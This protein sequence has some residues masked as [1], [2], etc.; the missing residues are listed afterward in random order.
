MVKSFSSA[1]GAGPGSVGMAPYCQNIKMMRA[2]IC[3]ANLREE[4]AK[5]G[6]R[7]AS[8][9]PLDPRPGW[10]DPPRIQGL[11]P[12]I[13]GAALRF[14]NIIDPIPGLYAPSSECHV[15]LGAEFSRTETCKISWWCHAVSRS[16]TSTALILAQARPRSP[17]RMCV[18]RAPGPICAS[19]NTAT[20]A[21]PRQAE[22][23]PPHEVPVYRRV[24]R[25]SRICRK[26]M[27]EN[28]RSREGAA[29]GP[30]GAG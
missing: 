29:T 21:R 20:T 8:R 27:I 14:H 11:H 4:F 3:L 16:T 9:M 18:R 6:L 19:S 12:R 15:V 7:R 30:L 22:I 24:L 1:G 10:P 28:G 2:P 23:R 13:E 25:A 5:F 17:R 26:T